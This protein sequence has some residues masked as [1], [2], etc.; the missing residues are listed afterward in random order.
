MHVYD[1]IV[2]TGMQELYNMRHAGL[3][4]LGSLRHEKGYRDYG[5]DMDNTDTIWRLDLA[6]HAILKSRVASSGW[7]RFSNTN[8]V[9]KP[10][11]VDE[12]PRSGVCERF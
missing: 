2:E 9:A 7:T 3:R 6:L 11:W 8:A 1:H 12:A 10:R 5:H 4:A